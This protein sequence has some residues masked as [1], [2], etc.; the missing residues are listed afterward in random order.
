M[1]MLNSL[2]NSIQNSSLGS[3]VLIL[4]YSKFND[5]F[6]T[7]A[8]LQTKVGVL[9]D[10]NTI[11]VSLANIN[12]LWIDLTNSMDYVLFKGGHG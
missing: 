11:L 10:K 12:K 5:N 6:W 1:D 9:K 8:C 3:R 4:L 7:C 2:L